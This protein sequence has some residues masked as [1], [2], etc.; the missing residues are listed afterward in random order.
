MLLRAV[1]ALWIVQRSLALQ[2]P[3]CARFLPFEPHIERALHAFYARWP[4][5]SAESTFL[6]FPELRHI[7]LGA[8][9]SGA[10]VENFLWA[11][12]DEG[13]G[14][15][16]VAPALQRRLAGSFVDANGKLNASRLASEEL[17]LTPSAEMAN[18]DWG[19]EEAV[20]GFHITA[21]HGFGALVAMHARSARSIE[22]LSD[23]AIRTFPCDSAL[24]GAVWTLIGTLPEACWSA[25]RSTFWPCI[26]EHVPEL[27][28]SCWPERSGATNE[29]LSRKACAHAVGHAFLEH[30]EYAVEV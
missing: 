30:L 2:Q 28:S 23:C 12:N 6:H 15:A 25:L 17:G 21:M 19:L 5:G 3:D 1:L 9:T 20:H 27:A 29:H 14:N 13:Q 22:A 24:H 4:Y 16:F 26:Q 11:L 7:L 18:K 10:D 8:L